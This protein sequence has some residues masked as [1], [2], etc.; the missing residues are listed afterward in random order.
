[1]L[2]TARSYLHSSAWTQ[3]RNVTEG[4]TEVL[5]RSALRAMRT[6]CKN[7]RISTRA[8]AGYYQVQVATLLRIEC[9]RVC[10]LIKITLLWHM[11]TCCAMLRL[12]EINGESVLRTERLE[13]N[14]WAHLITA[15]SDNDR[16]MDVI[17]RRSYAE[18]PT[19]SVGSSAYDLYYDRLHPYCGQYRRTVHRACSAI[20][21]ML[22][23]RQLMS[24]IAH[25][26]RRVCL[27]HVSNKAVTPVSWWH[28]GADCTQPHTRF[29]VVQTPH[30]LVK[31]N[32]WSC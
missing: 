18:R 13:M 21:N 12:K 29:D 2:K 6:R 1:M 4:Q 27:R 24:A 28:S 9:I 26:G 5:P 25:C 23:R 14:V 16:S 32:K 31:G 8:G 30:K 3:Y 15:S 10:R 17:C 20:V 11:P 7:G 22:R 19:D